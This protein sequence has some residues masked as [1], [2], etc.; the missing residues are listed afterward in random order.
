MIK[1]I[2]LKTQN[3]TKMKGKETG[4]LTGSAKLIIRRLKMLDD[5]QL[6]FYGDQG[7][8][9]TYICLNYSS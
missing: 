5:S 6:T 9:G 7:I 2:N 3:I 8:E 1:Y 4:K